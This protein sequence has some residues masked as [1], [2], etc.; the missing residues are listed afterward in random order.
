MKTLPDKSVD[1]FI[2]DLPFGCLANA[3]KQDPNVKPSEGRKIV[4]LAC[5]WDVPIDLT[6]FWEQI[7]RLAK[8]DHTPVLLFCTTRFGY[9][10]IASNPSWF[11]YDLVWDKQRGVSFLSANKMPMRSHE[12]LYVFAKKGAFYRR[13]DIVGD[14]PA[15]SVKREGQVAKVYGGAART[16]TEGGAGKR[17]PVSI[18]QCSGYETRRK[19]QHPTEKPISLY[20]WLLQ[21]YCPTGGTVLDP[22]FG[23]CNSGRAAQQLGLKYI[24][25]EMDA[26][27]FQ[28]A[29]A[30]LQPP[31]DDEI[32]HI[33]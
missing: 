27:F 12:M 2:C 17:C 19:G 25:I 30:E 3:R 9:D 18:I 22:T 4:N 7:K 15:W 28:K 29:A 23:S 5:A 24:G 21:R 31:T 20:A 14:F 11:R 26:G 13:V 10:L 33:T 6:K 8:D 16:N 1:C 32:Q